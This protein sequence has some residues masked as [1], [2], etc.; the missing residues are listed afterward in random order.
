M[1]KPWTYLSLDPVNTAFNPVVGNLQPLAQIWS[2]AKFLRDHDRLFVWFFFFLFWLL[3]NHKTC[4]SMGA[5]PGRFAGPVQQGEP[6]WAA[7]S[8]RLP[9]VRWCSSFPNGALWKL[10]PVW[11]VQISQKDMGFGGG[12]L[13]SAL[14]HRSGV[15]KPQVTLFWCE[16]TLHQLQFLFEGGTTNEAEQSCDLNSELFS[17]LCLTPL[18]AAWQDRK[19]YPADLACSVS[20][21][22][23]PFFHVTKLPGKMVCQIKSPGPTWGTVWL[24]SML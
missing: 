3:N 11:K 4:L 13:P 9:S 18:T 24:S 8:N 7:R 19:N 21:S 1:A 5:L 6:P 23:L 15:V 20:W 10:A 2:S 22:P 16:M 12:V 14:P 17:P